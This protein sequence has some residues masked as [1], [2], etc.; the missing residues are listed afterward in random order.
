[1]GYIMKDGDS[2]QPSNGSEGQGFTES[3]CNQCERERE[4]RESE[5]EDYK[6]ACDILGASMR[7][8]IKDPDYPKEWIYKDG[9]PVC[10]AF[11][12]EGREVHPIDDKT[13]P[14]FKDN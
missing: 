13:L 12:T 11:V 1:M 3:W 14:L 5:C 6:K 4:Y 2:Y 9:K 10:T 8:S 7:Y